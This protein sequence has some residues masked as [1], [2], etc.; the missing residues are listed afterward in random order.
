M[1]VFIFLGYLTVK[2]L[3]HMATLYLILQGIFR[4]FS[5]VAAPSMTSHLKSFSVSQRVNQTSV[6]SILIFLWFLHFTFTNLTWVSFNTFEISLQIPCQWFQKRC[7][8]IF[9]ILIDMYSHLLYIIFLYLI[10][11]HSNLFILL[12]SSWGS[13]GKCTGVLC[14]S[15]LQWIMFC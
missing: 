1:Y 15:L 11:N 2:L 9:N 3:G 10:N 5:N 13:H 6:T 12:Y 7:W 4:L 14:H 8:I